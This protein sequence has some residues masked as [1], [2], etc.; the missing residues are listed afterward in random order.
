VA[1]TEVV[2]IAMF[3]TSSYQQSCFSVSAV[4]DERYVYV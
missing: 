2:A 4:K 1:D 3:M